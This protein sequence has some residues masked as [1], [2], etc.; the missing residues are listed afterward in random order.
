MENNNK[1]FLEIKFPEFGY[2]VLY[3]DNINHKVK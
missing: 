3:S 1:A 2:K